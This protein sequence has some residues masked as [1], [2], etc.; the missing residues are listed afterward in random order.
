VHLHIFTR[1]RRQ[2][3]RWNCDRVWSFKIGLNH[4]FNLIT[5]WLTFFYCLQKFTFTDI[6]IQNDIG[7]RVVIVPRRS[8]SG[9][10]VPRM[11]IGSGSSHSFSNTRHSIRTRFTSN[12]EESPAAGTHR[13]LFIFHYV[14]M[15]AV[16]NLWSARHTYKMLKYFQ[17]SFGR[18]TNI[19]YRQS[20]PLS[21]KK[22]IVI[23]EKT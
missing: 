20:L 5:N 21:V 17:F 4:R 3:V 6:F 19:T 7:V 18:V 10:T 12:G 14:L 8:V 23:Y 1:K 2:I 11:L 16:P 9:L 13:G 15:A 22:S